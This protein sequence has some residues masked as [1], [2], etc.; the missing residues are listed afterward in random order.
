MY[1]Q[2]KAFTGKQASLG[3]V[4]TNVKV[5]ILPRKE[6]ETTTV[7][8]RTYPTYKSKTKTL[9]AK[10]FTISGATAGENVTPRRGGFG[11]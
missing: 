1:M 2:E 9:K 7:V 8:V 10:V 3:A 11:S 5:K 4:S 6:P